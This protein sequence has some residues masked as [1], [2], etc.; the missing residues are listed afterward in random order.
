MPWR[1]IHT[2]WVWKAIYHEGEALAEV[3]FL[4][5]TTQ[6]I[7]ML[8][9]KFVRYRRGAPPWGADGRAGGRTGQDQDAGPPADTRRARPQGAPRPGRGRDHALAV[10]DKA[11][12][13]SR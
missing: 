4:P 9:E 5:D 6:H 13:R 8:G 10:P 2:R 11:G 1:K 3:N 7:F 12:E